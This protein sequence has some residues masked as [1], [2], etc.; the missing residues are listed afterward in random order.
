MRRNGKAQL[1]LAEIRNRIDRRC[2][3]EAKTGRETEWTG[4]ERHRTEKEL[5]GKETKREG[6]DELRVAEKRKGI[7]W[8]GNGIEKKGSDTE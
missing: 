1:R 2:N 7:V 3:G 8:R 5:H 4:F 6:N